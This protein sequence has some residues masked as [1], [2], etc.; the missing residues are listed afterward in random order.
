P[1]DLIKYTIDVTKE[2]HTLKVVNLNDAKDASMKTL[3]V[4]RNEFYSIILRYSEKGIEI[5]S[6]THMEKYSYNELVEQANPPS[7]EALKE[8]VPRIKEDI[9]QDT[10]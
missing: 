5:D 7:A 8:A 1:G 9:P 4:Q 3:S 6:T 2:E 10:L